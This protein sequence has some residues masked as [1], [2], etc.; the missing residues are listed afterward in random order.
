MQVKTCSFVGVMGAENNGS[1]DLLSL[2]LNGIPGLEAQ[3]GWLSIPFFIMYV[4]AVVGNSLIM[5]AVQADSA[6]H[7]PM[8]L[9]LSML[10]ISEVGVSVSTLPAVTGIFWFG[11]Y[12]IDF[13]GCLAQMFFLHT[14]SGMESGV[15]LA[16][17]SDH[18]VAI[19]NPLRD[20]AILTL[21]RIISMGL[22]ITL[23]SVALM[24]PLPFLLKQLPYCH[25][26]ILSHSYYLH[27]DLI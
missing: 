11:T 13:D 9:F 25:I 10:A 15:L 2:F 3:H 17:S 24:A 22:G 1:L 4:V 16:M 18:F 7:E 14:F 26:N 19:Y 12:R 23:K 27:S 8:Y 6:L 20:T 21:P 5:A